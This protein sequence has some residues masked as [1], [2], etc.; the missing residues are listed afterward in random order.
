[1]LVIHLILQDRSALECCV[2][3]L[4]SLQ[5]YGNSIDHSVKNHVYKWHL[6][7]AS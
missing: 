7:P 4:F 2:S 5:C 3:S 6:N 1:M